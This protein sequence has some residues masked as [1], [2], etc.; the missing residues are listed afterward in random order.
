MINRR[1]LNYY[2]F[3]ENTVKFKKCK[4]LQ[5]YNFLHDCK[6]MKKSIYTYFTIHTHKPTF[7]KQDCRNFIF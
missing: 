1:P 7:T 2:Y 4:K 5:S 6:F 3:T